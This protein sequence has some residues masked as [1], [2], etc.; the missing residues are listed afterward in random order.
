[1]EN[2]QQLRIIDDPHTHVY[3]T[4]VIVIIAFIVIF[5][6]QE[7]SLLPL[8][9]IAGM[10]GGVIS[11]YLRVRGS[12]GLNEYQGAY[13]IPIIQA[14]ISPL[15]AGMLA[16][17]FHGFLASG[18]ITGHLF[19]EFRAPNMDYTSFQNMLASLA[20]AT[21]SDAAKAVVWAFIA[22]FSERLVPNV[23]D[24]MAKTDTTK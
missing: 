2:S 21:N 8:I 6:F 22:G 3:I 24:V 14:Y 9:V 20:P 4:T 13:Q 7:S 12:N 1:M 23:L 10:G 18:I 5:F 15:V 19:P 17:V 16:L 11:T